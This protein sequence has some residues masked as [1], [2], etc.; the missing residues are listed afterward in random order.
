MPS[1][2][3]IDKQNVAYSYNG[4]IFSLENERNSDTLYNMNEC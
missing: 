2:R 3:L 4:I 1:D